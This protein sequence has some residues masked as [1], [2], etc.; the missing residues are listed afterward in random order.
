MKIL[1]DEETY[2]ASA[3]EISVSRGLSC[4]GEDE[5]VESTK[6]WSELYWSVTAAR[7]PVREKKNQ[8]DNSKVSTTS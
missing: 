6:M 3:I 5:K 4:E 2:V 1:N 8:N 7:V